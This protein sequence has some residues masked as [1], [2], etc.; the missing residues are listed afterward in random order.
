MDPQLSQERGFKIEIMDW[1]IV[2]ITSFP[3]SQFF[4]RPFPEHGGGTWQGCVILASFSLDS[5][6]LL[7]YSEV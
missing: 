5:K 1:I 4:N 2:I 3:P 6:E 7:I